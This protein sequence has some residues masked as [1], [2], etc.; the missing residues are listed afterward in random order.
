MNRTDNQTNASRGSR[1]TLPTSKSQFQIKDFLFLC[2]ANWRWFVLSLLFLG[3][4]AG[5][6]I[7]MITPTYTRMSAIL[8]K[9][10]DDKNG[11]MQE[12]LKSL[13]VT[14]PKTDV[15]NEMLTLSSVKIVSNTVERLHLDVQYYKNG[16]FHKELVYGAEL[17]INVDFY[18]LNDNDVLKMSVG[19]D[20]NG[21]VSL[22]NIVR[23]G[24]E[25]DNK[26]NVKLGQ[27]VQIDKGVKA[28]VKRSP[29]Y[30]KKESVY[31]QVVRQRKTDAVVR[32]TEHLKTVLRKKES[33]I[34]DITYTDESVARAEDVLNTLLAVYNENWVKECNQ[35]TVSTNAFI[36]E[37]L[38]MIEQELGNVDQ[39]ISDYKSTHLIPNVEQ[40]GSMAMSQAKDAE[41]QTSTI[42]SQLY[43]ARYIRNYLAGGQHE[44]QLLPTN[45]GIG[46]ANIEGQIAEYNAILLRRNNHIANSSAQ[47]PLV[48]DLE[49]SLAVLRRSIIQSLDNEIT[50]LNAHKSATNATRGMAVAKIA[51]NPKQAK[52]LLSVERQQKVKEQLYLFLLQKREENELS[53]VFTAYK[54]QLLDP[55]HG[56]DS[57]TSPKRGYIMAIALI[58][59]LAIPAS[60]IFVRESLNTTVRGRDDLD[61]LNLPF[62]GEIPFV[63]SSHN[64]TS[65]LS[66]LKGLKKQKGTKHHHHKKL[67]VLVEKDS[68]DMI[69]EAFR[70]VRAN[71][72]FVLGFD[73]SHKVVMVTAMNVDSGKTF[74]SANLSTALAIKGKKVLAIDLDMRKGTLSHYTNRSKF[75]VSNYL[76]GQDIDLDELIVR[77]GEIDVLPCGTIPPNPTELL[78]LPRFATLIA[79]VRER[80]DYVFLDCPPVDIVADASIIAPQADTTLFVIRVNL[81]ERSLLPMI[82]RWHDEK[83]YKNISLL[84]N[85]T[86]QI[87]DRYG[88]RRYG[89]HYGYGYNYGY[90]YGY[91]EKDSEK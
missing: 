12:A 57:P 38:Y 85:C 35:Q 39:N 84:L 42:N 26:K 59:G 1:N 3:L 78:S 73:S 41:Q 21:N 49:Q 88:Y 60:I 24:I 8:F 87:S 55:P 51:S 31:L 52:Y 25:L 44:N 20:K 56:E 32:L 33:T 13:G 72:E 7:K 29:Y 82:G 86:G 80:Y 58:L 61:D 65:F 83:K 68:R 37:R 75:G 22:S 53:Q 6:S 54:T 15:Q 2:L 46:N 50:M 47:N 74:I 91:G 79:Q 69:N 4:C 5:L 71:F 66:R 45:S 43:M 10:D 18:G 11:S 16:L 62:V 23:N 70:V 9:T 34:I 81:M 40:V 76:S 89:Y 63:G 14:T 36:K 48:I 28:T 17:P 27:G 90:R 67:K 30:N 19:V 64:K 77:C